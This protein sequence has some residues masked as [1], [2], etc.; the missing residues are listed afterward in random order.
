VRIVSHCIVY[1]GMQMTRLCDHHRE[2]LTARRR[3]II[4]GPAAAMGLELTRTAG[5]GVQCSNVEAYVRADLLGTAKES[6]EMKRKVRTLQ[7]C[8]T[9]YLWLVSRSHTVEHL[10]MS[11]KAKRCEYAIF[12]EHSRLTK[13]YPA[14]ALHAAGMVTCSA[15]SWELNMMEMWLVEGWVCTHKL[16][17]IDSACVDVGA[18]EPL[19]ASQ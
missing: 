5:T 1:H 13:L 18:G 4:K 12:V 19:S 7:P 2:D 11:T 8:S 14:T 3:E 15:Q 6:P 16:R 17:V 9:V 10:P